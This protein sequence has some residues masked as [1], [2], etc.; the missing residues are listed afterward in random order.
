MTLFRIN[1]LRSVWV[2]AQVPEAQRHLIP[3]GSTISARATGWPGLAFRGQVEA[4]LPQVDSTSRTL[5]VRAVVNNPGA[6]LS[7]GMFVTLDLLGAST[8]KQLL[9]PSEAIITTGQR[10]VV[11]LGRDDGSFDVTNVTTGAEVDGKTVILSGLTAGQ[12]I[13]LSGQFLIDSEASLTSTIDRL[14]SSAPGTAV[15]P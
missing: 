10:T 12:S 8:G 3:V 4:V 7:P 9:V 13:V 14:G 6:K 2:N 1:G 15:Q 5:T 11:I